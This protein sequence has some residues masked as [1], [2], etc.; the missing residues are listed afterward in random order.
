MKF[1]LLKSLKLLLKNKAL[2]HQRYR[3]FKG[4][5]KAGD[6]EGA[7]RGLVRLNIV[8]RRWVIENIKHDFQ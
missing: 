1:K 7:L 4:Q 6:I 8:D 5:V 3:T 2:S